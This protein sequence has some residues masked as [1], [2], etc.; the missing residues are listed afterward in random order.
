MYEKDEKAYQ[1][2][3]NLSIRKYSSKNLSTFTNEEGNKH[4]I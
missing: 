4:G 1:I 2:I 3:E